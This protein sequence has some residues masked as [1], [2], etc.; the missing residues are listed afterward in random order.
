MHAE[1]FHFNLFYY[2]VM[3]KAEHTKDKKDVTTDE[4]N[5]ATLALGA[6]LNVRNF[7]LSLGSDIEVNINCLR[8]CQI[9]GNR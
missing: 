4:I 1:T 8:A 5:Q 6:F 7:F 3:V 9:L 2:L